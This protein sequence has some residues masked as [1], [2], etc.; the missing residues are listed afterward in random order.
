MKSI[1]PK[2]EFSKNVIISLFL[3]KKKNPEAILVSALKALFLA[4]NLVIRR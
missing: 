2:E 3:K 4:L 1:Y